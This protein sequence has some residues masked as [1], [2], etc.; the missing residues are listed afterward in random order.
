MRFCMIFI[1]IFF[2]TGCSGV[3]NSR[4]IN[5][6]DSLKKEPV[7]LFVK[8]F[9][10][11]LVDAGYCVRIIDK[12]EQDRDND[13]IRTGY[14]VYPILLEAKKETFTCSSVVRVCEDQKS[15]VFIQIVQGSVW[16]IEHEKTF[17]EEY[18]NIISMLHEKF[19]QIDLSRPYY[20]H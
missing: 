5:I 15:I 17:E 7:G 2:V 10:D 4:S 9:G 1:T 20:I 13:M 18:S 3:V 12:N 11:C 16:K 19:P 8:S 6:F 14:G